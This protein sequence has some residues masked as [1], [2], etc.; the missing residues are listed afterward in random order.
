MNDN[1][2]R[3]IQRILR[4]GGGELIGDGQNAVVN[5]EGWRVDNFVKFN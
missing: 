3:S 2:I 1:S 5:L 4:G